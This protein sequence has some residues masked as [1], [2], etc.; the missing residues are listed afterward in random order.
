MGVDFLRCDKCKECS[1]ADYIRQ[2]YLCDKKLCEDCIDYSGLVLDGFE[3]DKEIIKKYWSEYSCSYE[4]FEKD[5]ERYT[6]LLNPTYCCKKEKLY[7]SID[8]GK[9]NLGICILDEEQNIIKWSCDNWTD[10]EGL[11]NLLNKYLMEFNIEFVLIEQQLNGNPS[12]YK[13]MNYLEMYFESKK[14]KTKIQSAKLKLKLYQIEYLELL[15]KCKTQNKGA[16]Y[17]TRKKLS[18]IKCRELIQEENQKWI[19]KFENEKKKDDLS[20]SYLQILYFLNNK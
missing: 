14:I 12:M 8:P 5:W 18:I 13:T 9:N 2:C 15:S 4:V 6:G 17:R 16:Q 19:D 3:G 1:H 20:D 10:L 7:L 11:I